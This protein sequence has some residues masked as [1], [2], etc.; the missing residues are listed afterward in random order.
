MGEG[1]WLGQFLHIRSLERRETVLISLPATERTSV[2]WLLYNNT[3]FAAQEGW[4]RD[5]QGNEWWLIAIKASFRINEEG[6][7]K[8]LEK[9]VPVNLAPI[10]SDDGSELLDDDDLMI[11]K[12]RTDVLVEGNVHAQNGEPVTECVARLKVSD[13]I[14]KSVKVVGDRVFM[15]GAASVRMSRPEPFVKM[16]VTW[17]RTYGGSDMT[18][19]KPDWDVRNPVGVGFA[20]DPARLIGRSGPNFEYQDSPFRD[21]RS[22]RPAGFGAVA[23]HWQPRAAYAGTYGALWEQTRNP[24]LPG[25]FDRTYYQSAPEDQQTRVPLVGY[26]DIRLGNFTTDGFWQFVLPRVT[27]NIVTSFTNRTTRRHDEPSIHTVRIKPDN[28]EF[29]ITWLSKL[30]I[31]P[32]DEERLKWTNVDIRRRDVSPAVVRAGIWTEGSDA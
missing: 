16:P 12:R 22:G 11:E 30:H 3:P 2:M 27:F 23:R 1:Q 13:Q 24:L 7:Q 32:L 17:R 14:D 9:Q 21:H 5:E 4:T 25:D 20:V 28:R 31:A 19:K 6:R 26:E 29:S 18:A 8:L 10:H 15:P